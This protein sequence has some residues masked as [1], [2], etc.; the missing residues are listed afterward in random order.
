VCGQLDFVWECR[1]RWSQAHLIPDWIARGLAKAVDATL[2]AGPA[3]LA[4]EAN[5]LAFNYLATV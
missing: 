2:R 1:P 5:E 3:T 4:V